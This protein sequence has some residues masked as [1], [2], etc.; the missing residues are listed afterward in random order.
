MRG[1]LLAGVWGA[2]KTTVYQRCIARLIADGCQS[3]I[4]L[5]QAATLTTHT[6]TSGSS[7]DHMAG[8]RS[9]LDNL[10]SFLEDLDQR[11]QAS[12]LPSHR[13]A[14]AWTP[15]CL[16]EGFG[17]DVPVYGLPLGRHPL[18]AIEHRLAAIGL[19]L[20]VLRVPTHRI[21]E[22]CIESTR[23][24]RGPRWNT[25][26]DEFGPDDSARTEHVERAQDRLMHWAHSSPVPLHII[27]VT[28]DGWDDHANEIANLI[29]SP[30]KATHDRHHPN[31][32]TPAAA[33]RSHR[34]SNDH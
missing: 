8:I 15:T 19:H 4:A 26:L 22:Q 27:D 30:Q 10:T 7:I 13:F 6:Y 29:T 23:A 17:F 28:G 2:G 31:A 21:R 24:Q 5:P 14:P 12:T 11:F 33:A 1:C 16:L 32:P 9:W 20:V 3:L 34:A 25:Y 18:L